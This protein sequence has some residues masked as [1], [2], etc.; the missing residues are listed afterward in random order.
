MDMKHV[1]VAVVGF[2]TVGTGVVRLLVEEGARLEQAAG[3]RL[4][5]RHICDVDL[6]RPR[7]V[8]VPKELLTDDLE[9][10]LADEK[11]TIAVETVGGTTVAVDILKRLLA[12]GKDVVTANKAALAE[13]GEELFEAA[14]KAGRSISFE[15]S[16][17]AGIPVIRAIRDG[18]VANRITAILGILNGTCNYILTQMS[19]TDETYEQALADAQAKGYAEPDPTL[20]VSGEDATHKLAI[21][22][23]LAFGAQVRVGDVYVEG[24]AGLDPSDITYGKQLGYVLKLLAIGRVV[25]GA[26]SLRVHPTF[27]PADSPLATVGGVNNALLV[28]GHAVGNTFYVGPGAGQMPTAS[29]IVADIVDAAIG[30]ARTTFEHIAWLAGRGSGLGVQPIQ[31]VWTRYYLRFDVVDE[32]GVL[33]AI[34]G[35]LGRN[36]ISI[37]SVLQ[38]ESA[39]PKSVP[40]VIT[41]HLAREGDVTAA[42]GE[43]R[44]L[45]VVVGRSVRIRMLEGSEASPAGG[46][47]KAAP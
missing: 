47:R 16:C 7:D 45:A 23:G 26:L 46:K 13:R 8:K 17:A 35:V 31:D 30:R 36:K 41:T 19:A 21:L 24:I 3:C 2:G 18:L 20:D 12:A 29:S 42:L 33:A 9:R 15:A 27:V 5:L 34:A 14:R 4:A 10:I 39:R 38:H 25:N 6:K 44:R 40:L 28:T 37:A 1:G 43:I 32:P 11:T 22:A